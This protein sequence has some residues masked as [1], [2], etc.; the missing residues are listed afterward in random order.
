MLVL[1]KKHK[2]AA[3]EGCSQA[4][5]SV[6]AIWD[7]TQSSTLENSISLMRYEYS[8][9]CKSEIVCCFQT[10][11]LKVIWSCAAN[12]RAFRAAS[13]I[14]R[15]PPSPFP[16]YPPTAPFSVH[17]I[18]SLCFR[19][20][21]SVTGSCNPVMQGQRDLSASRSPVFGD[22]F[23][24][25]SRMPQTLAAHTRERHSRWGSKVRWLTKREYSRQ[26]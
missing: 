21:F 22:L 10:N 1:W 18:P 20:L 16:T 3:H 23:L 2:T 17:H 5:L 19:S 13:C 25:S 11:P 12:Y 14:H 9:K 6:I 8:S 24:W 7:K 4:P 15:T 26:L